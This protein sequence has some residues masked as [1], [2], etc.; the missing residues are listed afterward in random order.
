M[1]PLRRRSRRIA[2]RFGAPMPP[3]F[4][5]EST[6][7][8]WGVVTRARD[9]ERASGRE[10]VERV[11]PVRVELVGDRAGGRDRVVVAGLGFTAAGTATTF[12]ALD[13]HAGDGRPRP[14][15]YRTAR[16][17]LALAA[18]LALPVVTIVD[19]PGA[20]PTRASEHAG[21]AGEIARTL[22]AITAHPAPTVSV[23]V[24]EGGSGGALAFAAADRMYMLE[25]SIFSVIAPEGAAAI[26]ER[27]V[28]RAPELAA[29][30]RLT[31]D[32]MV[33]LGIADATLPDAA[34]DVAATV[35]RA[36]ATARP[37][38]SRARL[39]SATD[40]WRHRS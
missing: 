15:G 32:D 38:D 20:D 8:V 35:E 27:D 2:R 5:R 7:E 40:A 34:G 16:R 36:L 1:H 11:V 37:G 9:P 19:T 24:G 25:G 18:R 23:V 33:D 21:L 31:A 4:G 17:L 29:R 3:R 12:L 22:A 10:W 26:L 28:E 6:A 14:A 39:D 30:L 13:R